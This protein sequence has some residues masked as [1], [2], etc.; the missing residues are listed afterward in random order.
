LNGKNEKRNDQYIA[1]GCQVKFQGM[2]K[3]SK[4]FSEPDF[5]DNNDIQVVYDK[6]QPCKVEKYDPESEL[7]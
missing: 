6:N 4:H 2:K 3:N 7:T 1:G 5:L